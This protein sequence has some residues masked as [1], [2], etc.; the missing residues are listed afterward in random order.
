M[1]PGGRGWGGG[2][3]QMTSPGRASPLRAGCKVLGQRWRAGA[4]GRVALTG[5]CSHNSCLAATTRCPHS[6]ATREVTI[7]LC[8]I[9][10]GQNGS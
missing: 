1:I 3:S 5:P 2:I 4:G 7:P 6:A 8:K 10:R 9:T